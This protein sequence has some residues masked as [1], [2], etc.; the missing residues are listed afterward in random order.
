MRLAAGVRFADGAVALA[1]QSKALE[2]GAS[3][4]CVAKLAPALEE[5]R[6]RGNAD[7]DAQIVAFNNAVLAAVTA[8]VKAEVQNRLLNLEGLKGE[9]EAQRLEIQAENEAGLQELDEQ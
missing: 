9:V 1:A 2:D 5:Q 7:N 3:L 8:G 6:E 4:D